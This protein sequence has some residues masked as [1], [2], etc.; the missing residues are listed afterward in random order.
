MKNI[1]M[2]ITYTIMKPTFTTNKNNDDN[3]NNS[4][5]NNGILPTLKVRPFGD[6]RY[7]F[8]SHRCEDVIIFPEWFQ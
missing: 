1:V 2:E 4:K 5:N 6:T 8:E 3:N 7:H